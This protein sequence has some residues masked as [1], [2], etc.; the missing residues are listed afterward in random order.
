MDKGKLLLFQIRG[1]H[2]EI[3]YM[4]AI[5]YMIADALDGDDYDNM[6]SCLEDYTLDCLYRDYE[7]RMKVINSG[8]AVEFYEWLSYYHNVGKKITEHDTEKLA[9]EIVNDTIEYIYNR[10]NFEALEEEE[11]EVI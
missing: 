7:S 6:I 8:S 9:M 11:E 1:M 10:I 4:D 3:K 5:K 2:M